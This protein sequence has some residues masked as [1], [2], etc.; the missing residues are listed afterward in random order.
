MLDG[1]AKKKMRRRRK[2]SYVETKIRGALSWPAPGK[3]TFKKELLVD[4][5]AFR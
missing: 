1:C 5:C 4:L 3:E 2:A